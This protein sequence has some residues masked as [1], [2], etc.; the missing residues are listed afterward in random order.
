MGFGDRTEVRWVW[1]PNTPDAANHLFLPQRGHGAQSR[2][3]DRQGH[4]QGSINARSGSSISRT[5]RWDP[6]SSNTVLIEV[7]AVRRFASIHEAQVL[8]YLKLSGVHL[9]LLLN[10]NVVRLKDGIKRLV[11]PFPDQ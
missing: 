8:P 9:G 11:H 7:K 6:D 4:P 5:R 10:F 2:K 1:W 3:W